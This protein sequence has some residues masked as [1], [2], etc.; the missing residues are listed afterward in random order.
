MREIRLSGSGEGAVP[1]RPISSAC[2][3]A[4]FAKDYSG[5]GA[6]YCRRLRIALERVEGFGSF[7]VRIRGHQTEHVISECRNES[8]RL[9]LL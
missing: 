3:I 8:I 2:A 5:L 6:E 7:S 1:S 4:A 9:D